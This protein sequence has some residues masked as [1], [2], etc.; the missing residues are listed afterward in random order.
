MKIFTAIILG[1]FVAFTVTGCFNHHHHKKNKSVKSRQTL[2]VTPQAN[3]TEKPV[4]HAPVIIS[5]PEKH[6]EP[7]PVKV[8]AKDESVSP[9]ERTPEKKEN[10]GWWFW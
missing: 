6:A 5:K 8:P 1:L 2:Y 4:V 9:G 10:E 7:E 3:P